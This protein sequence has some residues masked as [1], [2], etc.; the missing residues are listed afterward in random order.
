M[1]LGRTLSLSV[2]LYVMLAGA[3]PAQTVAAYSPGTRRYH[4]IAVTTRSTD[5]NGQHSEF[6]ITTEQILSVKITA[7]AADTLDFSY[8]MD[9][10]SIVTDPPMTMPDISGMK[11]TEVHGVMSPFG[12]VYSYTSAVD[13]ND[14][15]KQQ[16]VIG[17]SKFL[18]P[19]P[20]HAH[21]GSTWVDTTNK[22]TEQNGN[23]LDQR[24][25]TTSTI[26]ADTTYDG[27]RAW[28]VRRQDDL[29]IAG[30]QSSLDSHQT[31]DG[32]GKGDAIY[33]I[34]S[35]GVYLGSVGSQT[36]QVKLTEKESG[37]TTPGTLAATLRVELVH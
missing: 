35:T 1:S 2:A 4:L 36:T 13:T 33:Y 21:V 29:S 11:G 15:G 9:S 32:H 17:M 8:T 26:L 12:K 37:R 27:Q 20:Q 22:N 23:R 18:V 7:R 24:T 5:Q 14:V 16:L 31:L 3:M 6:R 10:S 19:L 34:S 28:R 25:I 30:S